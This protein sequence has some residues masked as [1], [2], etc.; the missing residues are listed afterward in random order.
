MAQPIVRYSRRLITLINMSS[1]T[2]NRLNESLFGFKSMATNGSDHQSPR[3]FDSLS[4]SMPDKIKTGDMVDFFK[5]FDLK[6]EF[7][8]DLELVKKR[9]LSI[10]RLYHPD[11]F[12]S[13]SEE[14]QKSSGIHSST[15]NQAFKTLQD[16]YQRGIHLLQLNGI[17][18]DEDEKQLQLDDDFLEEMIDLNETILVSDDEKLGIVKKEMQ[19]RVN[20]ILGEI[21]VCFK[22]NNLIEMKQ[23]LGRL[24]F[25]QNIMHKIHEI[26]R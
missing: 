22:A 2:M 3:K 14:E 9:F 19:E 7:D 18:I 25:F 13:K 1:L 26:S 4:I 8:L 17:T 15:A 11:K 23:L 5:V 10:Q 16:P 21:S 24:K 20:Q 12:A 6:H